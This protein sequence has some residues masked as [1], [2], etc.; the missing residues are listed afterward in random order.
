MNRRWQT[1]AAAVLVVSQ[2]TLCGDCAAGAGR[3]SMNAEA[4]AVAK[5]LYDALFAALRMSNVS[6]SLGSSRRIWTES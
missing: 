4:P 2:F 3:R 6:V 5:P 1:A